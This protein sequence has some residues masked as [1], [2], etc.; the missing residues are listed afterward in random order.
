MEIQFFGRKC[1]ITTRIFHCAMK[2]L[3]KPLKSICRQ[4]NRDLIGGEVILT[5]SA[6]LFVRRNPFVGDDRTSER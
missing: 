2:N 3:H 4:S 6:E 5:I 1:I